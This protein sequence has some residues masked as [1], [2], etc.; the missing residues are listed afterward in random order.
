MHWITADADRRGRLEGRAA[1][2][3]SSAGEPKR[4]TSVNDKETSFRQA[5]FESGRKPLGYQIEVDHI[6]YGRDGRRRRQ[7]GLILSCLPYL[8]WRILAEPFIQNCPEHRCGVMYCITGN[9]VSETE[10]ILERRTPSPDPL[11]GAVDGSRGFTQ[12]NPAEN[13]KRNGRGNACCRARNESITGRFPPGFE[14]SVHSGDNVFFHYSGNP[15]E[16]F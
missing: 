7:D 4:K 15:C 6:G 1:A 2:N 5:F 8:L 13:Q 10:V 12:F 3:Q 14:V 11:A 9:G 16:T